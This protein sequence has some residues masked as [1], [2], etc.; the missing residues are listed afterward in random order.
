MTFT[1]ARSDAP[2]GTD[3]VDRATDIVH[4]S[5][6]RPERRGDSSFM[7][8]IPFLVFIA[9]FLGVPVFGIVLSAF[10]VADVNDP[11]SYVPSLA[12]FVAS[13]RGAS[14]EAMQNSL[15]ISLIA[16]LTGGIIGLALA[17]AILTT[18]S[19]KL[20]AVVTVLTSVLAN[21]GGVPLA[22]SF[23]AAVGNAG[24]MTGLLSLTDRGFTLYSS[25][26]LILMYQ[27][28]LI[29]T[30]VMVVLPT[31][32]GLRLEWK[33]AAASVGA[34]SWHFWKKVGLPIATPAI[35]A[36]FVLLFGASFATHASA[37]ALIGGGG[38]P[39]ITLRIDSGL[40]GGNLAGQ[41]N[42]AMAL[43]VNMIIVALLVLLVYM[44]LQ[45]RS[46]RWFK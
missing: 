11:G 34:T 20:T 27:Y 30:M 26:G 7:G 38:V 35:L 45:K 8:L 15:Q 40:A 14:W 6:V 13:F 9:F 24:I 39:L 2:S 25:G 12:N 43:G 18:R 28:F 5:P 33:E 46:L 42:V 41:E 16:A 4:S 3:S 29:P 32:A 19:K 31:L 17:Q 44:P 21:S 36:G 23:I 10:R 37:A 1:V 22:F